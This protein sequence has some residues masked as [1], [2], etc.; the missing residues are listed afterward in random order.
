MTKC[1]PVVIDGVTVMANVD[2]DETELDAEEIE[3]LR[4]WVNSVKARR[5]NVRCL[6]CKSNTHQSRTCPERLG[7]SA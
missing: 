5:K 2:D 4:Q 3:A 7:A 1:I 6:H